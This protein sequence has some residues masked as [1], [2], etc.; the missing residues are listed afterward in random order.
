MVPYT[1]IAAS[2]NAT[3]A[4]PAVITA[5]NRWAATELLTIRSIVL[6]RSAAVGLTLRIVRST[7]DMT[8]SGR[9]PVRN[10]T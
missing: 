1:P 5:R 10:T 9:T 3:R 4:K 2:S 7:A 8:D 6:K